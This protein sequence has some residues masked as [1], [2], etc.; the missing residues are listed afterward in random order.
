MTPR[1]YDV[2]ILGG[3]FAGV[4]CAQRVAKRLRGTGKTVALIASENHMVFQPMLA[5]VVG[6][7]ATKSARQGS[8]RSGI[9]SRGS[10]GCSGSSRTGA[11]VRIGTSVSRSKGLARGRFGGFGGFDM[12]PL[13]QK[14]LKIP[15]F[16]ARDCHDQDR[17][18]SAG[19]FRSR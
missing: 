14:H 7:L 12:P 8:I 15:W 13:P 5:E 9:G 10:R 16:V 4:Y 3:G 6:G 17:I 18:Q 1:S 19:T 2:L 11:G